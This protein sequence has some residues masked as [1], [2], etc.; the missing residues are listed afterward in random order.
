MTVEVH[1]PSARTMARLFAPPF[2]L[3]QVKGVG[4]TVPPSYFE[5]LAERFP[6]VLDR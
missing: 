6:R 5:P 3:L 1:Y 2:R 4:V